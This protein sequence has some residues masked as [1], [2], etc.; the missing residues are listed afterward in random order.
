LITGRTKIRNFG[1]LTWHRGWAGGP[2]TLVTRRAVCVRVVD[3]IDHD[4]REVHAVETAFSQGLNLCGGGPDEIAADARFLDSEAIPYKFDNVF[5]ITSAHATDDAAEHGLGHGLGGLQSGVG[6]Q[7]DLAATVGAAH[8]GPRDGDLL[9][10]QGGRTPLVAVPG[11]GPVGLT[12]RAPP[13]Q[14]GH[15]VLQEARGDQHAQFE[16]QA[17][18][19][20]LHQAEQF[21]A[22]QGE[23][24]LAAGGPDG[25]RLLGWLG[26]VGVL[27]LRIGSF[28]GGSSFLVKGEAT[29]SLATGREEP[30]S[31]LFN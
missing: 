29:S 23:L 7:R 15:L 3:A 10:S 13:A 24:D 9:A 11:V 22:I 16:R 21:I 12:L 18:Q 2:I 30:S 19:G 26:L 31:S 8:A 25:D 14:P 28:Q 5:I 20:I 6:L 17:L 4:R 27:S 1:P